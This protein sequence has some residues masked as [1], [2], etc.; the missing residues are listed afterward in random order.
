MQQR[1]RPEMRV[2]GL[3]FAVVIG[4]LVFAFTTSRFL[5]FSTAWVA[6]T[7]KRLR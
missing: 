6:P 7:L 2:D 3:A 1:D 5:L 4:I